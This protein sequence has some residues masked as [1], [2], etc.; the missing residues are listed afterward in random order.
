LEI[1]DVGLEADRFV[2]VK[3]DKQPD[4]LLICRKVG[5]QPDI[6]PWKAALEVFRFEQKK[7]K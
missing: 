2:G 4:W 3:A 7:E 1:A 6:K 5:W